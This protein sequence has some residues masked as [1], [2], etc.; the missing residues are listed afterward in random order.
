MFQ[1]FKDG[2]LT[3]A[4]VYFNDTISESKITNS[5]YSEERKDNLHY[6]DKL[7]RKV[8][9]GIT[10]KEDEIKNGYWISQTVQNSYY[11]PFLEAFLDTYLR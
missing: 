1:Y 9:T 6:L 4:M 10:L 3:D 2:V 5:Y 11:Q 7:E 8:L